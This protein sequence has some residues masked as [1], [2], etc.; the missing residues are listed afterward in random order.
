MCWGMVFLMGGGPLL[1][2]PL[3]AQDLSAQDYYQQARQKYLAGD[4]AGA[5]QDAQKALILDSQQAGAYAIAGYASFKLG[6]R[7]SAMVYCQKSLDLDPGNATLRDFLNRLSALPPLPTPT[8]APN[9]PTPSTSSVSANPAV[10]S[11]PPT[12][13]SQ[14]APTASNPDT[15]A[16]IQGV[17]T[18]CDHGTADGKEDAQKLA[19]D[20]DFG[21]GILVGSLTGLIGALILSGVTEAP[22]P[23]PTKY[24]NRPAGYQ[25][26]YIDSFKSTGKDRKANERLMGG[27]LGTG[28][29][30]VLILAITAASQNR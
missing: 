26:C 7:S 23:D 9:P 20:G 25:S 3:W 28:I 6:D 18:P 15:S 19:L 17:D 8:A 10:P 1:S 14:P 21:T 27:L 29:A 4:N 12:D 13:Q 22:D 11:T 16:S 24:A 30:V 2:T 5:L